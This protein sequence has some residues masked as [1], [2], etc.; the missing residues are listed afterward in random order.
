MSIFKEAGTGLFS[1]FDKVDSLDVNQ[2]R[3]VFRAQIV[4]A[5]T[6]YKG[7]IHEFA[8]PDD[9][10]NEGKSYPGRTG[11]KCKVRILNPNMPH[12]KLLGTW[13]DDSTA[14]AAD[15][16]K[17][18]LFESFLTEMIIPSNT[19]MANCEGLQKKDIVFVRMRAGDNNMTYSMQY[20]DFESIDI[21]WPRE[22]N[23]N[24]VCHKKLSEAFGQQE[25]LDRALV[26][27]DLAVDDGYIKFVLDPGNDPE[28]F[29]KHIDFLNILRR[30]IWV[31]DWRAAAGGK[32]HESKK[33]S[34]SAQASPDDTIYITS[35]YRSP[36]R[37]ANTMR[38]NRD[39][40]GC[41]ESL[42]ADRPTTWKEHYRGKWRTRTGSP[43]APG[44]SRLDEIK[45]H[46]GDTYNDTDAAGALNDPCWRQWRLYRNKPMIEAVLNAGNTN[47]AMEDVLQIQVEA[48]TYMSK[49]MR[50]VDD[51]KTGIDFRNWCSLMSEDQ[52]KVLI[53]EVEF[54]GG[55]AAVEG[56]HVHIGTGAE[57]SEGAEEWI[58]ALAADDI[59]LSK[60]S[61]WP[62]GT[63]QDPQD[64]TDPD[65]VVAS[66]DL[67]DT[68]T[69][70][71]D[72]GGSYSW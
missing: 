46:A 18:A 19:T 26:A 54:L 55:T 72:F 60:S 37:Q 1:L 15:L 45:E 24:T 7:P 56:N 17:N 4:T 6:P 53:K 63:Y 47:A 49:H 39:R 5:P 35:G 2:N 38:Q 10:V 27:D 65:D 25:L 33:N 8:T 41:K 21:R 57:I 12:E 30:R 61:P 13:G 16:P 31:D 23:C 68:G 59:D 22:P 50:P 51:P 71:G 3:S 70:T 52:H 11:W 28:V 66:A 34:S 36:S 20:C 69:D 40:E 67:D 58:A 43:P 14:A 32:C 9:Q 48:G 29:Q 44:K 62:P 64:P 42:T